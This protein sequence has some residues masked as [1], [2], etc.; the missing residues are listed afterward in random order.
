MIIEK[1]QSFSKDAWLSNLTLYKSILKLPFNQE[2]ASG[3]LNTSI[4]I[5]YLIQDSHYLIACGRALSVCAAKAYDTED[6]IQFSQAAQ[7]VIVAE[8]NLHQEFMNFFNLSSEVIEKTPLSLASH[9]YVS[10]LTS[11][12]WSESYP[13]VLASLL[14]C[15]GIYAQLGRDLADQSIAS[16]LYQ[17]WIDTYAS[18]EFNLL[19]QNVTHTIDRIAEKCDENTIRKMHEVYTTGVKL[20]WLF[21]DSAYKK[22]Y[23]GTH[24]NELFEYSKPT[25]TSKYDWM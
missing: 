5:H 9:H 8:R 11:I 21:W 6:V 23:W 10:F 12:A 16:N 13:I 15:F 22:E 4:F 2:L 18:T 25:E 14:P 17:A 19:M 7:A 1:E 20:E 24:L 3:K